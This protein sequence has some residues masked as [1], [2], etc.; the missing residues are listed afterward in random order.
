MGITRNTLTRGPAYAGFNST[1]FH[2]SDDSK[3]EIVPVSQIVKAALYGT[4]DETI[5]D[6]AIRCTGTPLTW[7]SLS[8]LFP[9]L[10]P[11]VGQRLYG[12]SDLPLTWNANNGDVLTIVNAAV[13]KM[14]DLTLGGEK[15]IL[16]PV[17]FTGLIAN[18]DDPENASS[19]YTILTG[20]SFSAPALDT[21][22]LTRQRYTATWGAFTGFTSFQAQDTWNISHELEL[23]PVKIQGRTVDMVVNSYRCMAKTMPAEPMMANIDAALL[24]QG[25]GAK[26]GRRLSAN[27]SDLVITGQNLVSITLKNA[28]LKTAGFVF[29]G[30]PLRNGELGWVSNWVT[31]SPPTFGAVIS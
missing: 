10:S 11:T 22:K 3:I 4:I 25:T 8:T 15:D 23:S 31:G 27:A 28:A 6:L 24:V 13:T 16:G 20:Q 5:S 30:K 2:F 19:Y 26:Q 14:P 7:T 9:Y 1:T 12:S 21:T 17:E 18:G 29:G